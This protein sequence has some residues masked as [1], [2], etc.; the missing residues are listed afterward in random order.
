V[1]PGLISGKKKS[2]A[3]LANMVGLAAGRLVLDRTGLTGEFNYQFTFEPD[4]PMPP[5]FPVDTRSIFKA[6]EEDLGLKLEAKT[7]KVEVLVIDHVA[8]PS[9]N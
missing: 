2:S 5:G 8:R 9:E 6:I 7:E 3:W 4:R 1:G